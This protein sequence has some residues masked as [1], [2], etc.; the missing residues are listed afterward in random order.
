MINGR[1]Q[2]GWKWMDAASRSWPSNP[3]REA[4]LIVCPRVLMATHQEPTGSCLS[5]PETSLN[6]TTSIWNL[7]HTA[8]DHDKLASGNLKQNRKVKIIC[9]ITG[10]NSVTK[11]HKISTQKNGYQGQRT[12]DE[13]ICDHILAQ[14]H[15]QNFIA[16][17]WRSDVS[18][19]VPRCSCLPGRRAVPIWTRLLWDPGGNRC[20]GWASNRFGD[21]L[22]LHCF[23][24]DQFGLFMFFLS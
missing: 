17:Y 24:L 13:I 20:L 6:L 22:N 23:D 10:W 7:Q 4:N 14:V 9:W 5:I 16:S 2:S 11:C 21:G 1:L 18:L 8:L 12:Y 3:H 15:F 19:D